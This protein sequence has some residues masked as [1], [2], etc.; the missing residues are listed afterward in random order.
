MN[1]L[2][3]LFSSK[4]API[5]PANYG[6]SLL[7]PID[8]VTYKRQL[9]ENDL[10][11]LFRGTAYYCVNLNANGVART[12]LYLYRKKGTGQRN[13]RN[14]RKCK[15]LTCERLKA[16]GYA[17]DDDS[18]EEVLE[19]PFLDLLEK[20]FLEDGLPI[21]GKFT[22]FEV[23]QKYLE[24]LGRAYWLLDG[25]E[26]GP[27]S[28]L[29]PLIANQV[30]AYKNVGSPRFVDEYRY[31]SGLA[32]QHFK[33]IEVVPFLY[34]NL[35]NPYTSGYGPLQAA[36]ERIGVAL[37]YLHQT[38]AWLNNRARP[39]ML[40]A[41]KGQG[42]VISQPV[43]KRIEKWIRQK[44]TRSG[45][46][47]TMVASE[48]LEVHP[49]SFTPKDIGELKDE[50]QAVA[51]IA[52]CFDIP[53]SM[54]HKDA[55]RASAGEGRKQHAHDAL[56]PRLRRIEQVLNAYILPRYGDTA[57]LF[58]MFDEPYKEPLSPDP[59]QVAALV[60]ANIFTPDEAREMFGWGPMDEK[61]K[62]EIENRRKEELEASK[63]PVK[64]GKPTDKMT[65]KEFRT[66]Y[67][68]RT[69]IREGRP[70]N[71]VCRH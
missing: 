34:P 47:G 45:M 19:H 52:R 27:P 71:G 24:T 14:G 20:P 54:L 50:E 7:P 42:D 57:K 48:P 2:A 1:P 11:N 36:A 31:Q 69:A 17:I 18:V 49:L 60:T 61:D 12:P 21:M 39:D 38:Q 32:Q 9:T 25:P 26:N 10:V 29:F 65:P 68:G 43:R 6:Q 28:Q 13:A 46:G 40:I 59:A 44:F 22:F 58:C 4:A 41:A 64:P 16:A 30:E 66:Y 63:P 53:L 37:S 33:P 8:Y 35:T 55:N 23:T 5:A 70:L 67:E 51:E 3:W 62:A 15:S 56:D